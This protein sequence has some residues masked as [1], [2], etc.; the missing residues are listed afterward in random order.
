[1]ECWEVGYNLGKKY[2]GKGYTTEALKRVL[3]FAEEE[4][5][6]TEFVGRYAKENT[7]SGNVMKKL[8]FQYEKEIPYECND[9]AVMREGIQCRLIANNSKLYGEI[10]WD[11]GFLCL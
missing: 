7:A 1:M 8:G 11:S 2:W 5:Q 9:G 10:L 6:L 3:D 4:L